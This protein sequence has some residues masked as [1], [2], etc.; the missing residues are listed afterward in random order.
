M[1][2][3]DRIFEFGR[4]CL[5]LA[6]SESLEANNLRALALGFASSDRS[7]PPHTRVNLV[8]RARVACRFTTR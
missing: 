8:T 4:L 1:L 5:S 6:G 3:F 7:D 2:A